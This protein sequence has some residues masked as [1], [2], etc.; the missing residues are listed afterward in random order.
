MSETL[1]AK[2]HG[3]MLALYDHCARIGFRPVLFRRLVILKGGVEAARELV[4]KPGTTGLERLIEA[5]KAEFS[6][7]AA[8]TRPE[9]RTLFSPL[10]I[11]QAAKRLEGGATRERSRGRLTAT[12]TNTKQA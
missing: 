4:F 6:I 7:E 12:I 3:E 9:Y 2:F 5:R 1:Q 10:E 11:K 8:M